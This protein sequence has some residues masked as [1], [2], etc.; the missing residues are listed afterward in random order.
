M[1]ERVAITGATG[2]VGSAVT[3]AF[4]NAG[5]AVRVLVRNSSPRALLAGLEV[6]ITEA[7]LA[8]PQTLSAALAG[9][10]GLVH[11]AADYRLFVTDPASLYRVN[12]DGTRALMQAALMHGVRRVVYT[13]SV[14]ALGYRADAAPA[15]ED[16][17][18]ALTD[19][20]GHYKR[21]KFLAEAEVSRLAAESGLPAVIVNPSAPVGPRDLKPTPTGR[22]VL[23]AAR[24]RM[25]AYLD[26]GLNIVHVDDVALGHLYAYQRGQV[27]RRY[28]LGG[29]NLSLK[30]IFTA[31]AQLAGVRP[32]RIKL[33]PGLL[34]PLAWLAETAARLTAT[35]PRL[36]RDELHMA[37]H[38]MY[39]SSARAERELGYSHR[40]AAAA[41]HDALA[42]YAEHGYLQP[43][44]GHG[45]L[46]RAQT[47]ASSR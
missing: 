38:P 46:P 10:T 23:E 27:G 33:A 25:P 8:A 1:P 6:E 3:R 26:T 32:P 39:Y 13:S 41:F 42:W 35:T 17:P 5:Y 20:I 12:V 14:A 21:S 36:T 30:D 34:M 37:R 18:A 31:L 11:V 15:D 16:T 44:P 29:E 43:R 4:L 22:M 40:P 24:G 7:D 19:M 9:C 47:G 45:K 28:I 2:F